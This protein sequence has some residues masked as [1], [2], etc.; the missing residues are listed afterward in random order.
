MNELKE[1]FENPI[2]SVVFSL[3]TRV[4]IEI[5]IFIIGIQFIKILRKIIRKSLEKAHAEKGVM[6]FVDSFVKAAL[7]IVLIFL[8][9]SNLGMDAASI[10]ALLGSA[11]VAIGLAVQGSLS[12]LAGGVLILLLKPFVVGDYIIENSSKQEGVVTEIHIFYTKLTTADNRIAIIPNGSLANNSI[13][14]VTAAK[15]RRLDVLLQISYQADLLKAKEVLMNVLRQ[16]DKNCKDREMVV[17]VEEL[18][19]SGVTMGVRCWVDCSDYFAAKWRIT[20]KCKLA[21]DDAK[22]EIPFPQMDIHFKSEKED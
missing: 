17:F 16:D 10:V 15:V 18:A 3:I 8:I 22:I 13:V 9:A 4:L 21:L 6:Q 12:N 11:G 14:N 20:E 7:Y 2:A 19:D 5:A 1:L